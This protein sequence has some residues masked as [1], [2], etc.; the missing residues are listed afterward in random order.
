MAV[1]AMTFFY[2]RL[3]S[4][5][6]LAFMAVEL[7]TALVIVGGT[8]A[9][10]TFYFDGDTHEYLTVLGVALVLTEAAILASLWRIT[11][12]IRPIREWI[13]G[14]RDERSTHDA[15]SAAINLPVLLLKRD[16][17]IPVLISVVPIC[18]VS[19]AILDL[20]VLGIFPL[21]AGAAVAMGY[22][23]ILHYLAVEAGMRP[24]LV[25]INSALSPR[26]RTDFWAVSLRTR[27]LV[28][29]PL[30][31]LITGLVVAALTSDG[32][33]SSNL[34]LDV[35]VALAVATTISLEL[36]VM[37]SKS[38]LRPLRDLSR[39]V[40]R[41]SEGDYDV[42]VAVTTGD[43]LGE[44]AAS[45][46]EMVAGL[47]ERERIREAFGTYLD[48]EVAEYILSEGF[49][50]EGVEVEVTVMFCDVR[51]FTEFASGATPQEVVGALNR[52]FEVIVPI[53]AR[54]GGH[55]DKFEGDGLLAVFG[56]PEPFP[57]HADRAVRA[58]CGIAA[59]VNDRGPGGRA[60]GRGRRQLGA[61]GRRRDRRRR[62]AQL[63][64]HRRRGQR[65]GAR[66]GAHARDRRR[67]PDH[68][69]DL[70]AAL[71]RVRGREPW[72]GRAPRRRRAGRP[73]RAQRRPPDRG[74]GRRRRR[75]RARRWAAADRPRP[76][77]ASRRAPERAAMITRGRTGSADCEKLS[78]MRCREALGLRGR[79][80][81]AFG[82]LLCGSLAL[83]T[84]ASAQSKAAATF[85]AH[86]SVEQVQV[87]GA[88]PG[89]R[90]TLADRQGK[91]VETRQA[92][93]L[94]G[95]LFRRVEPGGGYTVRQG[96]GS[97]AP[98]TPRFRVLSDRSAPPDTS[99]YD[100]ALPAGGY[101]YLTTRDGT[102]LAI[103][104]QPARARRRRAR[105]RPWS[106]TRA[107]ATP[108]PPAA[109]ARS[110]RS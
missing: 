102:K 79:I 52:L 108:T 107:T 11:G 28:A 2:K 22:S 12:Q 54:H 68:R 88:V 83:A 106:S 16:L 73:L 37:L 13:A 93:E 70:E 90:L 80:A 65:R 19:V 98:Q 50:E 91:K 63:L 51:G 81:R 75:R 94:G 44:L 48:E 104:V 40:D 53:I 72:Q 95:I 9:L 78:P 87:T 61:G 32:G 10:F 56:A 92:G 46:N 55:I 97:D 100:Q 23:A 7:Q 64:G 67:H 29:L 14:D 36:T 8:L 21:L 96:K 31:N 86:G 89:E 18:I 103:N 4:R 109:R 39:A 20:P 77:P 27:L 58:A 17:P 34:G 59:A 33:G 6:P 15:W 47:A 76:P 60:A 1:P 42:S 57:D 26:Q 25:D 82:L 35:L 101:G 38:I 30:I 71:A 43:E 3:G 74:A 105:T 66:R 62:A 24:V 110:R 45:F 85:T 41:V 84:S 69:R 5:Y 99:I 49:S